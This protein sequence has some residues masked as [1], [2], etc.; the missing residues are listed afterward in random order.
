MN[1]IKVEQKNL[2][3]II[4]RFN[5]SNKKMELLLE[6]KTGMIFSHEN[7]NKGWIAYKEEGV[8]TLYTKEK[9]KKTD[10]ENITLDEVIMKATKLIE[11]Y[12]M[13]NIIE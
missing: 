2:A 9:N 6:L 12:Q 10:I 4:T 3:N 11:E 1:T 8:V 7:V 13:R 5:D